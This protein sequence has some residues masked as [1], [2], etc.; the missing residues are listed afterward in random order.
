MVSQLM[1]T[2]YHLELQHI[3]SRKLKQEEEV[4]TQLII[5]G[6]GETYLKS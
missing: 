4:I 5:P 1:T 2:K 6:N 3:L